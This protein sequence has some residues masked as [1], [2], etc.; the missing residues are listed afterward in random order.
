MCTVTLVPTL[1]PT[2]A[3]NGIRVVCNRDESRSRPVAL[4]P[5]HK[6]FDRCR[7]V[8][9]VDVVSGGTWIAVND[10]GLMMT[11]L[12]KNPGD[13]RGA[14]FPG[15]VSR[16]GIIPALL[17]ADSLAGACVAVHS[18]D[19]SAYPPFRLV[20]A[21]TTD[22]AEVTGDGS[23]LAIQYQPMTRPVMFTSSGLGD[24][25]VAGPR[26]ELFDGWFGDDRGAWAQLQDD[27]H[28]H[29]WDDRPEL[30]V[31]MSREDAATVSVTVVEITGGSAVLTYN[32]TER[33][34]VTEQAVLSLPLVGMSRS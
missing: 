27:L 23:G 18:L 1:G 32:P 2:G 14:A 16:G 15:R 33:D 17:C 22:Y 7:A 9:P 5:V 13:M 26:H 28:R 21:D 11:L 24:A 29:R 4:P 31:N 34:A 30:S 12:N 20:I 6:V 8:M 3:P 25:W 10:S 19:A